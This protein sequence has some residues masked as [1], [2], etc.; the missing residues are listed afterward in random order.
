MT[1]DW[2]RGVN[3]PARI[4]ALE[5]SGLVGTGPEDAFDR[6]IELAV[7]VISAPRGCITLVDTRHTTAMSAVGFPE[8]LALFAPVEQS[9]CRFV[10]GSRRPLVIEDA[11]KDPRTTGDPA[12]ACFGALAWAGFPIEDED[13]VVLGTFCL[14][15]DQPRE[16]SAK[17]LHLLATLA[18][19][20]SS[21]IALF[22]SLSRSAAVA[23]ELDALRGASD[24][25]A[26]L[27]E[28]HLEELAQLGGPAA[29]LAAN[30]RR[31]L[32]SS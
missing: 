6:L 3:D 7:A 29:A 12:I 23:E 2:T 9:F 31:R 24:A 15:D 11:D 14:M 10:V 4:A 30:L 32:R 1:I 18:R 22:A 8:G 20:A 19:A 5:R 16:W 25:T 13:G 27:V 26:A 21:E 28:A 17:D